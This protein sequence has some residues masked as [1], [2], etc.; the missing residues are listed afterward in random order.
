MKTRSRKY[1]RI[2]EARHTYG[3]LR[4][5]LIAPR[6]A[7]SL[8]PQ[9]RPI[10]MRG[11]AAAKAARE[12]RKGVSNVSSVIIKAKRAPTRERDSFIFQPL[13]SYINL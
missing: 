9:S 2:I 12:K 1:R 11:A 6:A 3:R 10:Q 7:A 13:R 4:R 8:E 5:S